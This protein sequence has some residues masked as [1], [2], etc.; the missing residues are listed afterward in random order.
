MATLFNNGT[1][2]HHADAI[3]LFQAA[4]AMSDH[5]DGLSG[6]QPLQQGKD[7]LLGGGIQPFGRFIQQPEIAVMQ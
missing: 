1:I 4:E 2:I 7:M 3:H 5:D 6:D